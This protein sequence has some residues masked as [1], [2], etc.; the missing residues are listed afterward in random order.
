[1]SAAAAKIDI[2][3]SW[4]YGTLRSAVEDFASKFPELLVLLPGTGFIAL[5]NSAG[6]HRLTFPLLARQL[7]QRQMAEDGLARLSTLGSEALAARVIFRALKQSTISYF[8]PVAGL[9][10]F[11]RALARTLRELRLAG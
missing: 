2:V 11:S 4:S 6:V 3:Q 5:Q 8:S 7:A 10:G 1:M 9:P